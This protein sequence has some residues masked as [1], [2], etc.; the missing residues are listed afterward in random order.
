[1]NV[2]GPT[3]QPKF[4]DYVQYIRRIKKCKDPTEKWMAACAIK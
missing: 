3:V 4:M 2:T 1:M